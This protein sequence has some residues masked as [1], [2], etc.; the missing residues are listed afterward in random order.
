MQERK[1]S[2]SRFQTV[3]LS[4]AI[5]LF[6]ALY[7]VL[8]LNNRPAGDDFE[9]LNLVR[10]YGW[11]NGMVVYWQAWNTRWLALLFLNTVLVAYNSLHSFFPYHIFTLLVLEVALY[12]FVKSL[13]KKF[14]MHYVSGRN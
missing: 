10:D 4:A 5:I 12:R 2:L 14:G 6:A 9:F 8:S 3:F 7:I 11:W 13:F 1:N